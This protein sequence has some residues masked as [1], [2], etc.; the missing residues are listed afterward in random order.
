M[1]E[2]D[3]G[4]AA[5]VME[6]E[7]VETELEEVEDFEATAKDAA[8][9]EIAAALESKDLGALKEALESF[10]KLVQED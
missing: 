9:E 4:L 6:A 3:K 8:V 2:K 10:V 7:P 5:L 1:A